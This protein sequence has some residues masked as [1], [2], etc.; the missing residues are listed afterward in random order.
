MPSGATLHSIAGKWTTAA[1]PESAAS[2]KNT[3]LQRHQ[4]VSRATWTATS[5]DAPYSAYH[6]TSVKMR[7][8]ASTGAHPRRVDLSHEPK[9][10]SVLE[11]IPDGH[12]RCERDHHRGHPA[13][14]PAVRREQQ[15]DPDVD[16]RVREQ[17]EE[18]DPGDEPHPDSHHPALRGAR[19]PENPEDVLGQRGQLE[20]DYRIVEARRVL[21][22]RGAR[23]ER[24]ACQEE[25]EDGAAREAQHPERP[26]LRHF[27][28][29]L[30]EKLAPKRRSQARTE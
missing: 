16:A 5:P 19:A 25:D 11:R 14:S 23:R 30:K 24:D 2:A 18:I 9:E 17:E 26:P 6:F 22:H 20:T 10:L 28:H 13:R 3:P 15:G 12:R 21:A 1:S 4:P 8:R 29:A 27:I 7:S